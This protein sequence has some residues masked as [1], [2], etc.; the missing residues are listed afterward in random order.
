MHIDGVSSTWFDILCI[1]CVNMILIE[2][3]CVTLLCLV[4]ELYRTVNIEAI[5]HL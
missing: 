4:H 3:F 5:F 1:C 2:Y